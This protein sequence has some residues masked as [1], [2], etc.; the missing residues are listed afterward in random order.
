[1]KLINWLIV[2]AALIVIWE[3]L[4]RIIPEGWALVPVN[5]FFFLASMAIGAF[6]Y[7]PTF[8]RSIGSP[9]GWL[10]ALL[11]WFIVFVVIRSLLFPI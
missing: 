11:L 7:L 4:T 10:C 5:I 6:G 9:L 8:R 1:M 2:S 3:V